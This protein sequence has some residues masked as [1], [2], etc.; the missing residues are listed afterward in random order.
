MPVR[1]ELGRWVGQPR[2]GRCCRSRSRW[3]ADSHLEEA[4]FELVWGLSCQ[5]MFFGLLPVLCSSGK[6]PFYVRADCL[7]KPVKRRTCGTADPLIDPPRAAVDRFAKRWALVCDSCPF[8]C[9]RPTR[10]TSGRPERCVESGRFIFRP[11]SPVPI[12]D[13]GDLNLG[14]I[15]WSWRST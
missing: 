1:R 3:F 8:F 7:Q 2:T 14:P 12:R 15:V 10:P 4:G 9:L 6:W 5:V 13:G 11:R